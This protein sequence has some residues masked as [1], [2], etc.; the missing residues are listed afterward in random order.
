[1]PSWVVIDWQATW[2]SA[3]R[4]DFFTYDVI[5]EDGEYVKFFWRN[6]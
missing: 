2:D 3:L 6:F 5:N 1:V 4:F